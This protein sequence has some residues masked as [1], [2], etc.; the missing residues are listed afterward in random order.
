MRTVPGAAARSG[1]VGLRR[2]RRHA[3]SLLS[4]SPFPIPHSQP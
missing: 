3:R 1:A 2:S 4:D